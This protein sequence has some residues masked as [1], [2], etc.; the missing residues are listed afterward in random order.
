ME[1]EGWSNGVMGKT[2]W[3]KKF[4]EGRFFLNDRGVSHPCQKRAEEERQHI[5]D[6][7][8]FSSSAELLAF[9]PYFVL[10]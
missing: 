4:L 5:T 10:I 1:E 9:S 3:R 8:R 2:T 7:V 6:F